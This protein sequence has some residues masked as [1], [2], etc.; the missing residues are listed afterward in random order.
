MPLSVVFFD[1]SKGHL[2]A[3]CFFFPSGN[4]LQLEGFSDAD[5]ASCA[6]TRRS[7]T[8]WCMFLGDALISWK[9][10]KQARISKSS[11]EFEHRAMSFACSEI[12]WL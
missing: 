4:S 3:A 12:V 6:D 11:I 8:G 2:V 9:S 5:W 1:I 10:K 7:V